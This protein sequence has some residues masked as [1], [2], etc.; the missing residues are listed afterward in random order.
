MKFFS[1][2]IPNRA[3]NAFL[4]SMELISRPVTRSGATYKGEIGAV[5]VEFDC[6]DNHLRFDYTNTPMNCV[7][8]SPVGG[9]ILIQGLIA[10]AV[11]KN[12]AFHVLQEY[13][14]LGVGRTDSNKNIMGF[15][16]GDNVIGV[17][18]D[19]AGEVVCLDAGRYSFDVSN[20][21][22]LGVVLQKDLPT[23]AFDRISS[24]RH[25]SSPEI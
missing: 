17:G 23:T 8:D 5:G 3:K 2:L 25:I 12:M 16:L 6:R 22:G 20:T 9:P 15:K 14:Y 10:N 11:V 24:Y 13:E 18:V 1:H 21:S 19:D 4:E 7:K